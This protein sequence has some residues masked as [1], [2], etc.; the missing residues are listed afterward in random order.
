ME[1]AKSQDEDSDSDESSSDERQPAPASSSANYQ[2]FGPNPLTCPDDTIYHIREVTKDMTDDEKKDIYC[3][4]RFPKRDLLDMMACDPP[5]KDFSGAKP[6]NQV[7]ANTFA[8]YLEPYVRPYTEEDS[9]FLKERV[10]GLKLWQ[11]H[12]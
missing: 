11:S 10:C 8:T 2:L 9:A 4:S 5:D 6:T 12:Y 1:D 7:N 3:V